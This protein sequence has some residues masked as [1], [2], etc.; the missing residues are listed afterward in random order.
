[1]DRPQ[2]LDNIMSWLRAGYPNGV[3]GNDYLPLF[4]L[5]RRQVSEEEARMIAAALISE[6]ERSTDGT[7]TPISRIDASVLITKVIDELPQEA[8]VDRVRARL[9]RAGWPFDGSPLQP[10]P[11]GHDG[12]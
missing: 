1:M 4:A 9:E 7:R 12:A 8:D 3:P 10:P 5:L 11:A 6:G 2:F